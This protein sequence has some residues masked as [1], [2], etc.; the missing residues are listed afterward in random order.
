MATGGTDS[1]VS[2]PNGKPPEKSL[3]GGKTAWSDMMIE[4]QE[5]VSEVSN[6]G[7]VTGKAGRKTWAAVLGDS[8][9]KKNDENV[10]E[11][12][13]EK[14]QR[15]AFVVKDDECVSLMR[16]LG[17]DLRPGVH[18]DG[19]QVCPQGRGVIL[20][21][22]KKNIEVSRFCRHEVFQVTPT[23]VRVVLVRAAGK[24]EVV[25]TAKGIHPNTREAVVLDYLGRFGKIVSKK[26][27][28]GMHSEGPLAGFRNGDRSYKMEVKPGSSLGSYHVIDGK[29]VTLRYPGQNQTCARCHKTAQQCKGRGVARRCEAAGG[30]KVEFTD[31]ILGLWKDIQYSPE[32]LDLDEI[33]NDSSYDIIKEDNFTPVKPVTDV[34]DRYSGVSIRQFPKDCDNGEIMEF[35]IKSGLPEDRKD[36]VTMNKNGTVLITGIDNS[37]CLA[38][39]Q[40]VHGKSFFGK[41]IFC[42]GFVPLTPDKEQSNTGANGNMEEKS[43]LTPANTADKTSPKTSPCTGSTS[44]PPSVVVSPGSPQPGSFLSL[45][46]G[47]SHSPVSSSTLVAD[48]GPAFPTNDQLVRRHSL[49]LENR[50]PPPRSLASDILGLSPSLETSRLVLNSIRHLQDSLSDFKSCTGSDFSGGVSLSSSDD[51]DGDL[52]QNKELFTSAN[53]KKRFRKQKR[54]LAVTPTKDSF[55]KK[56]NLQVSPQ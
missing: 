19:V 51:T 14:D 37:D 48:Q 52:K 45:P 7:T 8:L 24:K 53:S 2:A 20:I 12:V 21:T 38:I 5:E 27:V 36:N 17:L 56:P 22:L 33:E 9:P 32:S 50:T 46:P 41:K 30:T 10:L 44:P 42:N 23:G 6:T 1:T 4:D 34:V 40:A 31:Y 43:V 49:S 35:L 55:L 25:V 3:V 28:Y 47:S 16:K 54:K 18:V 29:K 11:I 13:L 39:I 26:V 15:G